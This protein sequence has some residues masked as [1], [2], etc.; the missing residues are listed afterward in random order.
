MTL[1]FETEQHGRLWLGGEKAAHNSKLLA[2]NDVYAVWPAYKGA[3][4]ESPSVFAFDVVDGTGACNGDIPLKK[5]LSIVTDIVA[6]L[7]AGKSVLVAC[8]NGAHRSATLACLVL[9]RLTAWSASEASSYLT[10][11]RNIVDLNSRAPPSAYRTI[12]KRPADF[13]EEVQAEFRAADAFAT[14]KAALGFVPLRR[15]ALEAGFEAKF[16]SAKSLATPAPRRRELASSGDDSVGSFELATDGDAMDGASVPGSSKGWT[17]LHTATP[18]STPAASSCGEGSELRR[19]KIRM[20]M[21]D[22]TALNRKLEGHVDSAGGFEPGLTLTD[23]SGNTA[24]VVVGSDLTLLA[25]AASDGAAPQA[26]SA[27]ASPPVMSEVAGPQAA[28]AK[29]PAVKEEKSDKAASEPAVATAATVKPTEE[30]AAKQEAG[31][32]KPDASTSASAFLC[33]IGQMLFGS[34]ISISHSPKKDG[35]SLLLY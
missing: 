11:M 34:T 10:T 5:V 33:E 28:T 14:A 17:F 26:T 22:L 9:I 25:P 21:E 1:I 20:L 19:R 23:S 27:V 12:S 30:V 32:A 16:P 31:E 35:T 13:L 3:R 6:L 4:P 24:A 15:K 29:D 2:D 18:A 8:H 7:V